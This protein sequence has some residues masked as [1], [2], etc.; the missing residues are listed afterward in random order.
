MNNNPLSPIPSRVASLQNNHNN[1]PPLDFLPKETLC[2]I[3][4][5]N[6]LQIIQLQSELDVVRTRNAELEN[7][8]KFYNQTIE[9]NKKLIKEHEVNQSIHF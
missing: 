3:I 1:V 6:T 7:D 5:S 9:D 4:A 2:T 8:K